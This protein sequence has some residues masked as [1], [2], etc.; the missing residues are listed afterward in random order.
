MTRHLTRRPARTAAAAT[1]TALAALGLAIP[2]SAAYAVGLGSTGSL[3]LHWNGKT[4]SG[5][6]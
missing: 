3:V 5:P 2:A 1:A 4:W 6:N